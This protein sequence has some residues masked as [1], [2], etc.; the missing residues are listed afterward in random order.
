MNTHQDRLAE[1]RTTHPNIDNLIST[2]EL[3]SEEVAKV[4]ATIET[5]ELQGWRE[6]EIDELIDT[7]T[8]NPAALEITIIAAEAL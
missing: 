5:Y 3:T 1:V 4:L 6:M 8:Y 2:A 7:M